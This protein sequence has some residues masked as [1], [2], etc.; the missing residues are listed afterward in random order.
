[1]SNY[2]E[3]VIKEIQQLYRGVPVAFQYDGEVYKTTS[4]SRTKEGQVWAEEPYGLD[5]IEEGEKYYVGRLGELFVAVR[6]EDVV[7]LFPKKDRNIEG[8][9]VDIVF[10]LDVA[11]SEEDSDFD[12]W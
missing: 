4:W 12:N 6:T 5:S 7:P 2:K 3:Q 9:A 8:V 1:M 10:A 11:D